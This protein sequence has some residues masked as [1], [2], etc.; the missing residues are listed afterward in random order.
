MYSKNTTIEILHIMVIVTIYIN[1]FL[2]SENH[3]LKKKTQNLTERYT[4]TE[5]AIIDD[6][7]SK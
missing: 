4:G 2:G 1:R 3:F 6:H 5:N 7:A